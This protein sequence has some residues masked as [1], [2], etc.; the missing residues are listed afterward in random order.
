MFQCSKCG[1]WEIWTDSFDGKYY[2]YVCSACG[3]VEKTIKEKI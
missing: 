1:K 3:Y 2:I